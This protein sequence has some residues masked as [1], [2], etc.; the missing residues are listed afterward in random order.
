MYILEAN[1]GSPVEKMQEEGMRKV[2]VQPPFFSG[3]VLVGQEFLKAASHGKGT[4]LTIS[5]GCG[6]QNLHLYN[7]TSSKSANAVEPFKP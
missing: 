4:N 7:F 1:I 5:D 2:F 3:L 6:R